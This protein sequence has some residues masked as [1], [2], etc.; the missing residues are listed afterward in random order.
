MVKNNNLIN[1]SL[2]KTALCLPMIVGLSFVLFWFWRN[3][4]KTVINCQSFVNADLTS[5]SMLVTLLITPITLSWS[6]TLKQAS[7]VLNIMLFLMKHSLL[8][9]QI[10]LLTLKQTFQKCLIL[11]GL[12]MHGLTKTNSPPPHHSNI[13]SLMINGISLDAQKTYIFVLNTVADDSNMSL[14]KTRL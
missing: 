3:N 14:N 7:P 4:Y 1:Y 10:I 5:V 8:S 11:F 13:S 12:T 2:A 6:T 9:P